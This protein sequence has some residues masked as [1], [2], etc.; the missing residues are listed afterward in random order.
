LITF[1]GKQIFG[2]HGVIEPAV[3]ELQVHRTYYWGLLGETEV[4]GTPSGRELSCNIWLHN[5][6][7]TRKRLEEAVDEINSWIGVHGELEETDVYGNRI[8][9]N[10]V[11]FHGC[12]RLPV[13]GHM[14]PWR[15]VAG[16]VDGGWVQSARLRF[17][18]LKVDEPAEG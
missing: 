11:T 8:T 17:Y 3:N 1:D 12:D 2:T 15:D 13:G 16:T 4:L 14:G 7:A 18:Q 6:Y 5:Y 10:E 9:Y